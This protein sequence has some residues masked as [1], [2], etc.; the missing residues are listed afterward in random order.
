MLKRKKKK[1]FIVKK[2]KTYIN[3]GDN[4]EIYII[5]L[6]DDNE[7]GYKRSMKNAYITNDVTVLDI[8]FYICHGKI[9]RG[10]GNVNPIISIYSGE[11]LKCL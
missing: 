8:Y 9:H 11:Y 6:S 2:C 10:A 5:V 4:D 1:S 7:I 3:I